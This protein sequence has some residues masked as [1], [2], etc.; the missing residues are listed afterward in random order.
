MQYKVGDKIKIKSK[1]ALIEEFG[2][3]EEGDVLTQNPFIL[4]GFGEGNMVEYCD[5]ELTVSAVHSHAYEVEED[6]DEWKWWFSHDVV[7]GE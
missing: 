2:L 7:E 3:D 4:N 1:E 6:Q 5:R